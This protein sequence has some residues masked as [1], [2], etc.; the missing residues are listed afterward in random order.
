MFTSSEAVGEDASALFNMISGYSEP[1]QWHRLAIAPIWLRKRFYD[2]INREIEHAKAGGQGYIVAKMNSLIDRDMISKLYEA[3]QAGVKIELIVRGICGLRPGIEGLSENIT[4]R[5]IVGQFL[6][7]SRIYYFYNNGNEEWYCSSADWMPRNLD[8]R[9][10]ILFPIEDEDIQQRV[11]EILDIQLKDTI[12]AS[13]MNSDGSYDRIDLRGKIR[14]DSQQ[15][16]VDQA[17]SNAPKD[18]EY[19]TTRVF[20]PMT[21]PDAK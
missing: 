15:Y 7:H 11:Q 9:V 10:E 20:T 19:E 18:N 16:F 5:S 4:V 1:K 17:K 21:N 14:F 2:L 8:R 12:R 6:E 13:Q 3:S